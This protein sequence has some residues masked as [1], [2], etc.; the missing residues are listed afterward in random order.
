[1]ALG[2]Y[3][4]TSGSWPFVVAVAVLVGLTVGGAAP[5]R[6]DAAM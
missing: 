1:V 4:S 5:A 2:A 3:S 6:R